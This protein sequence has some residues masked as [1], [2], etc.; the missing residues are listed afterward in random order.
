MNE[1]ILQ[2]FA[3]ESR[4]LLESMEET[5]QALERGGEDALAT[6]FRQVHTLKGSAGIVGLNHLEVFAHAVES[7]L[8]RLRKSGAPGAGRG[9]SAILLACRDRF[10]ALLEESTPSIGVSRVDVPASLDKTDLA[11]L[12]SLDE[13]LGAGGSGPAADAE[14]GATGDR[15]AASAVPGTEGERDEGRER[16]GAA[17]EGM[18]RIAQAK[19]E[20]IL[21]LSSELAIGVSNFSQAVRGTGNQGLIDE[22]GAL[23]TL[24]ASLYNC[25][26]GTR[27]VPFGEVV[28]RLRR[29]VEDIGRA[30]GKRIRF[31]VAGADTEVE[32][33]VADRLSEPLLHLV[34]NAAD[35]G[36]ETPESRRAAGKPEEGRVLLKASREAGFFTVAVEDDG[37]GIDAEAVRRR[38]V[39]LGLLAETDKRNAEE[40]FDFLFEPGFSLS[41]KVTRWSGRGV[42]LDVVKR[43]VANLRGSMRL[44]SSLG[45]GSTAVIRLP[46]SLSLVEGFVARAGSLDLLVPFDVTASCVE[47][48]SAGSAPGGSAFSTMEMDGALIPTIDL[49]VFYGEDAGASRGTGTRL[50]VV[51]DSGGDRTGLLVDDVVETLTAA[52]RP[53]ERGVAASPGVAGYAVRGDGSLLLVVDAPELSRLAARGAR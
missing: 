28:E 2:A 33:G 49:A 50:A 43:S 7:R 53:F 9:A 8:D 1:E 30:T 47:L 10:A 51:I 20:A 14:N 27:M 13:S 18:A 41:E 32:K 44:F 38:A 48:P 37:G 39:F 26:L 24:A 11:V 36:I 34:R 3:A 29:A 35:H 40:L 19:L 6:L 4:E 12:V 45:E 23:E 15:A 22:A 52:V 16:V 21:A 5:V 31:D 42:G 46:V 17:G 25:V